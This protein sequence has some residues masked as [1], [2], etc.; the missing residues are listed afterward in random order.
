MLVPRPMS[1]EL[2]ALDAPPAELGA[3][4]DGLLPR[5]LGWYD[6]AEA[7]LLPRG[8]PLSDAEAAIARRLGVADPAR[9]RVVVLDE[10]PLPDD[11]QLLAL[12]RRH[13]L[14]GRQEGGRTMGQAVLLKPRVAADPVVLAHELVHVAQQER[15]GR[16]AFL[17]RYLL[18]L[19]MLGYA[20][21]P[22]ELEA[23]AKQGLAR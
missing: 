14:G 12:A 7:G 6:T 10:F 23:Y 2:A 19:Q 17:R 11:P 22:L 18:E 15:M 9:V 20:R 21:S 3:W 5:A 8:R 16:A 4:I 13:G 1:Q